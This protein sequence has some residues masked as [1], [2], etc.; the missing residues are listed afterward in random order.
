MTTPLFVPL[1]LTSNIAV[2]RASISIVHS[3]HNELGPG[4]FMSLPE[5]DESMTGPGNIFH[6]DRV[7]WCGEV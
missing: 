5:S 7:K 4:P 2:I 3:R 1:P 6:E